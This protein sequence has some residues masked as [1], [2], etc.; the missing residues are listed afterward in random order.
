[1][2]QD[3]KQ[4]KISGVLELLDQ[5]MSR[6]EIASHYDISMADC[7]RL[8]SHPALKGKKAKKLPAFELVDDITDEAQ[9]SP[10]QEEEEFQ[11][12]V[13]AEVSSIQEEEMPG[14]WS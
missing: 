8:F 12:D 1:M 13:A 5:G 6:E 14:S 2:S 10:I 3:K 11:A 9:G 7:R 4:I